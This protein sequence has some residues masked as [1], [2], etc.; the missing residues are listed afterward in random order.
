MSM[1]FFSRESYWLSQTSK[2]IIVK[3]TWNLDSV[4]NDFALVDSSFLICGSKSA[5]SLILE[6][7]EKEP[8]QIQKVKSKR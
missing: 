2:S 7:E 1:L 5:R 8:R 3:S 4:L 6:M